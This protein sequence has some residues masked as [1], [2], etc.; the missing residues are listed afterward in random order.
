M[1]NSSRIIGGVLILCIVLTASFIVLLT[2][3]PK[4]EEV[5]FE[6]VKL[7]F[8]CGVSERIELIITDLETWEDLWVEM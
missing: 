3:S 2:P 7:G 8:N 4:D 1:E 6:D 5:F